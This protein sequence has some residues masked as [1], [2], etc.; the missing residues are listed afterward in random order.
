VRQT[1]TLLGRYLAIGA[2]VF[3]IDVATFAAF[4]DAHLILPAATSLSFGIATAT[5]FTLNRVLNFRNFE[6]T[7]VQ[8]LGTYL[9]VAAIC[10][11]IQNAAVLVGVHLLLMPPLLAKIAGIAINIPIGFLGH[12]YLTFDRGIVARL[13]RHDAALGSSR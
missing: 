8:Q 1:G 10:L 11:A 6:R 4:V 13:R 5:H 3:C 9:I 12:R 2:F 7:I